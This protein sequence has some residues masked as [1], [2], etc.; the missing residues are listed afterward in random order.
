MHLLHLTRLFPALAASLLFSEED[1]GKSVIK[2]AKH[3]GPQVCVHLDMET[4]IH[5]CASVHVH[6]AYMHTE[7]HAHTCIDTGTEHIH[8]DAYTHA[9]MNTPICPPIRA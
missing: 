7:M 4:V 2:E 1:E 6:K 9:H 3:K 5:I 8:R